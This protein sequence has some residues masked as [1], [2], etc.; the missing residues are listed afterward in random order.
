VCAKQVFKTATMF[1]AYVTVVLIGGVMPWVTM[2]LGLAT[3]D[4][5]ASNELRPRR[6]N[7][8]RTNSSSSSSS[9][10][11]YF[12]ARPVE[13][14]SDDDGGVGFVR[15]DAIL[16]PSHAGGQ[17]VQIE[18]TPLSRED[19]GHATTSSTRPKHE[20]QDNNDNYDS[21]AGTSGDGNNETLRNRRAA[22]GHSV[23]AGNA[24]SP[25]DDTVASR[26]DDAHSNG[27]FSD[28]VL[29]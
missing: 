18:L 25:L 16:P 9:R 7:R 8:S 1:I 19:S 10:P 12:D 27:G 22:G 15:H 23:G 6:H 20:R 13:V 21:T 29:Q 2:R 28:I 4:D 5:A 24:V 14:S 3:N 17:E 11:L 26:D